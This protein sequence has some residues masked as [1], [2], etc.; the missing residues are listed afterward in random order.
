M[1]TVRDYA[2]ITP[3]TRRVVYGETQR[4][5]FYFG[6]YQ[7]IAWIIWLNSFQSVGTRLSTLGTRLHTDRRLP[8]VLSLRM[9]QVWNWLIPVGLY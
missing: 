3:I 8:L 9:A 4:P 2:T 1:L 7:N 5:A 6:L